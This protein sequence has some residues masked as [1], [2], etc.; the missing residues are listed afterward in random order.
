MNAK[1]ELVEGSTR[2]QVIMESPAVPMEPPWIDS[3][4]AFVRVH[5][6]RE[7]SFDLEIQTP[8]SVPAL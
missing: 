2:L 5:P 1:L 8:E 7:S 6:W 3:P 4:C